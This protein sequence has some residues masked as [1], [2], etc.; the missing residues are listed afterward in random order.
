MYT[1][2]ISPVLFDSENFI[3]EQTLS[4]IEGINI[5]P[6]FFYRLPEF[7]TPDEES[8]W[9]RMQE[10]IYGVLN[11]KDF[12]MAYIIAKNGAIEEA[13][14][15]KAAIGKMSFLDAIK[16]TGLIYLAGLL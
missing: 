7:F 4:A 8:K 16:K 10:R 9:W 2:L 13:K 3:S 6:S 11:G 14:V 15:V 12:F 5:P 1:L